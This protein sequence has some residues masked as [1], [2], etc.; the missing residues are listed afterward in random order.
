MGAYAPMTIT[1]ASSRLQLRRL[2]GRGRQVRRRR[3]ADA[4]VGSCAQNRAAIFLELLAHRA[5]NPQPSSWLAEEGTPSLPSSS[6]CRRAIPDAR[7]CHECT[8]ADAALD[9]GVSHGW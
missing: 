2:S 7:S 5:W 3:W 1:V 8:P 4:P 6:A 9:Y